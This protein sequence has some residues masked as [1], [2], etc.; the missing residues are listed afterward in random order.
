MMLEG[1]NTSLSTIEAAYPGLVPSVLGFGGFQSRREDCRIY[2]SIEDFLQLDSQT[3]PDPEEFAIR[4]AGMRRNGRS[5][6]GRFGFP[7][8]TCDGPLPH[9]VAWQASWADFSQNS[10]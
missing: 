6:C 10:C 3:M 5:P 8:T 7:V 4:I 9:P 2:F 1:E